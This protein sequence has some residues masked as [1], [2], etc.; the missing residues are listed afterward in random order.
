MANQYTGSLEHKAQEKFGY[1]AIELLEDFADRGL[2]YEEAEEQIG[3][4]HCTIR[5]WAKRYG[6]ELKASEE[7]K[8]ELEK[9]K[10]LLFRSK[11]INQ[12]NLLSRAWISCFNVRKVA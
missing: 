3:I 8:A 7:K 12:Y 10:T 9:R 2:S 5:K 11:Q 6:I 1:G 4:A